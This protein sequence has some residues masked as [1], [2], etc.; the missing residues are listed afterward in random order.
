MLVRFLVSC[1]RKNKLYA[2]SRSLLLQHEPLPGDPR[3]LYGIS[4]YMY[5]MYLKRVRTARTLKHAIANEKRMK[6]AKKWQWT[7]VLRFFLNISLRLLY[8]FWLSFLWIRI[9]S[10][11]LVFDNSKTERNYYNF[12]AKQPQS[13]KKHKRIIQ[14]NTRLRK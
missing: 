10:S 13:R 12:Y 5:F 14:I 7:D 11:V 8:F 4:Y 1:E 6:R 3:M 2:L 9:F